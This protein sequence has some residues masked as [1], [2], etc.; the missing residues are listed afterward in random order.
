[1]V[2]SK[3]NDKSIIILNGNQTDLQFNSQPGSDNYF[4]FIYPIWYGLFDTDSTNY[5]KANITPDYT[6]ELSISPHPNIGFRFIS[7]SASRSYGLS[8]HNDIVVFNWTSKNDDNDML[9]LNSSNKLI[10]YFELSGVTN[11]SL[12]TVKSMNFKFDL[13]INSPGTEIIF[14]H[15]MYSS[16]ETVL[17][18]N[19]GCSTSDNNPK[20]PAFTN[21]QILTS[22]LSIIVLIKLKNKKRRMDNL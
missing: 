19:M 22:F 7:C 10:I 6:K 9:K 1:M 20:I 12:N 2:G 15:N 11:Y 14:A 17:R 4:N 13:N 18:K 16:D 3:Y 21:N 5:F 8:F